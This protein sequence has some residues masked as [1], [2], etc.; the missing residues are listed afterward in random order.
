VSPIEVYKRVDW[1]ADTNKNNWSIPFLRFEINERETLLNSYE[2]ERAEEIQ[3]L[4]FI[5]GSFSSKSIIQSYPNYLLIKFDK[6]V[7]LPSCILVNNYK[8][9]IFGGYFIIFVVVLNTSILE[10]FGL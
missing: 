4:I 2:F 9:F 1:F 10:Y 5:W 6:C 7:G 3:F 8:V